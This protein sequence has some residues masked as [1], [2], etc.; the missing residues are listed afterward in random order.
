MAVVDVYHTS[1]KKGIIIFVNKQLK[2]FNDLCLSTLAHLL[3]LD[4]VI[5]KYIWSKMFM[6]STYIK[7]QNT[8][9]QSAFAYHFGKIFQKWQTKNFKPNNYE[10]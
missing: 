2:S 8:K 4:I 5:L 3:K 10:P 7:V 6:S 1:V 9:V